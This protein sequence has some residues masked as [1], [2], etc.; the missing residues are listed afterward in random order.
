M[1]IFHPTK[2]HART[3]RRAGIF[4]ESAADVVSRAICLSA[5]DDVGS[6]LHNRIQ[7]LVLLSKVA[8][9]LLKYQRFLFQFQSAIRDA[10]FEFIV[11]SFELQFLS[12]QF[13][14]Y[15]YFRP[16]DFGNN[17]D[18]KIVHCPM[19]VSLEPIE[20]G[21]MYGGDEDDRCFLEPRMLANNLGQ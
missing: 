2:S 6:R 1:Q 15:S 13:G 18:G 12:V 4:I 19:L 20:V 16:Q 10:L 5:E 3:W 7:F 21:Q 11:Q 17:R 9:E 14:E 8:V